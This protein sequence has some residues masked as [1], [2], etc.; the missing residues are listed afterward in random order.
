MTTDRPCHDMTLAPCRYVYQC[1]HDGISTISC[2]ACPTI[3]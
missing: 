3:H 2:V 1:E